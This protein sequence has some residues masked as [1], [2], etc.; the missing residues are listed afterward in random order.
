VLPRI[1]DLF[2]TTRHQR[3]GSGIGLATV[4]GI[5]R[6]AGGF[7]TVDSRVGD[8]T[9]FRVYFP[10]HDAEIVSI[11]DIPNPTEEPP[12]LTNHFVLLVDDEDGIRRLAAQALTN[13]GWSVLAADSGE[14][15]LALL[16]DENVLDKLCAVVSDI[17]LPGMDGAALVREIRRRRPGLPA[18]LASGYVEGTVRAALDDKAGVIFLSKPYPLWTMVE[19]V[20]RMTLVSP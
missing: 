4:L 13:G 1:F 7:L 20:R 9:C 11:P 10:R 12:A 3:G 5:V 18:I 17:V 15:A 6:E 14:A 8:G 16:A 2:F 19:A